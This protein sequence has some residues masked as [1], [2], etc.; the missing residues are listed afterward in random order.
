[1]IRDIVT[2]AW[3]EWLEFLQPDPT[4]RLRPLRGLLLI[5]AGGVFMGWQVD[6]DFG[7]SWLT[8][9]LVTFLS[10][11][12]VTAVIPDSIAG[13]RE[14]HTLETLLATRLPDEAVLLGKVLAAVSYGSAM[15]FAVLPLGIV[16]A[17]LV[18]G[19]EGVAWVRPEVVGAAV[20]TALL[21]GLLVASL[22]VL[23]SLYAPTA[24][25]ANQRLG[26]AIMGLFFV[27]AVVVPM[28][29][30][31]IRARALAGALELGP[32]A[33]LGLAFASLAVL[34]CAL[35]VLALVRF[36]RARLIV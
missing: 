2:V 28:L 19:S 23:L 17:N 21:G 16:S 4:R 33:V 13:E 31:P 24:R 6:P 12:F 22:G 18:H 11:M 7:R 26:F 5:V 29:P 32:V 36:R 15:G 20:V 1:V 14:R 34:A 25:Q 9:F 30:E 8:V 27:P 3:K 35:L 10:V